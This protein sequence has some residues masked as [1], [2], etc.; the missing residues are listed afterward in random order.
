MKQMK[1]KIQWEISGKSSDSKI[2]HSTK[3]VAHSIHSIKFLSCC[4]RWLDL[5]N[6]S[7]GEKEWERESVCMQ[8][9]LMGMGNG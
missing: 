8:K 9:N 4:I 7:L 2:C 3:R 5:E 6:I 1:Q